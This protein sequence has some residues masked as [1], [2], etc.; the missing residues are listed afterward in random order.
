M[1]E[2]GAGA[3]RL[4]VFLRARKLIATYVLVDL[5][6]LLLRAA[7]H[8]REYCPKLDI[9][10]GDAPRRRDFE[11]GKPR[12]FLVRTEQVKALP[13]GVMNVL[14]NFNSFMEMDGWVRDSYIEQ[15]YRTAAEGALFY[16]VNRRQAQLPRPDGSSFDNNPLH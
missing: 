11:T 12:V 16:N 3:G 6:E 9:R 15:M 4:L 13:S 5:D 14:L 7:T 10:Y 1:L 2:V 8:L